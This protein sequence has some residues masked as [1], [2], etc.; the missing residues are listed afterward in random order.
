MPE[1]VNGELPLL[2]MVSV[3]ITVV[4][5]STFPNARLPLNPM[6]RVGATIPVPEALVVFTPLV[7]SLL[8]V[9]VPL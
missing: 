6:I 3:R 4:L 7:A 2:V 5:V 8:T 9:T 1:T